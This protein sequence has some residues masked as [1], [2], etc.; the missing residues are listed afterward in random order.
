MKRLSRILTAALFFLV[1]GIG[2][3]AQTSTYQSNERTPGYRTFGLNGGLAYQQS[4]LPL[5]IDGGWGVG[6]TLAKNIYY[7]PGDALGFD[8]RGRALY[9]ESYG[10]DHKRSY[11]VNQNEMLNGT[12]NLDYTK[13]AGESGFVFHNNKTH[14]GELGLEGVLHF[15]RLRERTNWDLSLFGGIGLGWYKARM[16]Q[17]NNGSLYTTAYLGIDTTASASTI[18]NQLRNQ[19]LDDFYETDGQGMNDWGNLSIMPGAGIELGYQLTPKFSIGVGHKVTFTNT[20]IFDG[21]RHENNGSPSTE[22]DWHHYTNLN[23]RWIIDP[24]QKKTPGPKVELINPHT[25]VQTVYSPKGFVRARVKNVHSAMEVD[26][27]VNGTSTPFDFDNGI[28]KSH[29]DLQEGSNKIT[30]SAYN[31][32]GSDTESATIVYKNNTNDNNDVVIT[33]PIVDDKPMDPVIEEDEDDEDY[34]DD[35]PYVEM[36]RVN[37]TRPY[38]S[39]ETVDNDRYTVRATIENVHGRDD[40]RFTVNGRTY[41][42]FAFRNERFEAVVDLREG[43]NSIKIEGRNSRGTRSDNATIKLVVDRLQKPMV[44]ITRPYRDPYTT[45]NTSETIEATV[46]PVDDGC[47]VLFKV[48]GRSVRGW[49]LNGERFNGTANLRPGRN[50]VEVV[51]ANDAGQSSD[52]IIIYYEQPNQPDPLTVKITK[53]YNDPHT[54]ENSR[55]RIDATIRPSGN[56]CN[57]LFKVN[58]RSVQRF[59]LNGERFR[60]N[61]DLKLGRNEIEVIAINGDDRASDRVTIIYEKP[62]Q[63]VLPKV[64]ITTPNRNGTTTNENRT[65]IKANIDHV[66]R[67]SDIIFTING[68]TSNDFTFDADK[69]RF[70]GNAN[71]KTGNNTVKIEATNRDGRDDDQVT[72]KYVIEKNP[73]SVDIRQPKNKAKTAKATVSFEGRVTNIDRKSDIQLLLNG[74]RIDNFGF[75]NNK[76]TATLTLRTGKNNIVLKAQ[77]DDGS[78]RDEVQIMYNKPIINK[79]KPPTVDIV[80]PRK[81]VTTTKSNYNITAK[82]THVNSSRDITVKSNGKTIRFDFDQRRQ[83]ISA[84]VRLTNGNN[85]VVVTVKNS[86]GRDSDSETI[87]KKSN[88]SKGDDIVISKPK[89]QKPSIDQFSLSQPST[90]PL[91]PNTAKTRISGLL[92]NVSSKSEITLVFDGQRVTNFDFNPRTGVLNVIMTIGRGKHSAKVTVNTPGGKASKTARVTF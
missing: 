31:A 90:D 45:N 74:K 1:L 92:K 2:L 61:A 65:T 73:P 85:K 32:N 84:T 89:Y 17:T 82:V 86:T 18:R 8:L 81:K 55:E 23:L 66:A 6:L 39:T 4:D 70:T 21:V 11:S 22:N 16:N 19:I 43:R 83:T 56:G 20:D 51:A 69:G 29:F 54:T 59:D 76:V 77:N 47:N 35:Q 72:I 52:R 24:A 79:P 58:G 63:E 87:V 15:N 53:P 78:D 26:L 64:D 67:K 27:I 10:L 44:N 3:D 38:R 49:D 75:S 60:G 68:R 62:Y 48:N 57:V 40:V 33:D 34:F 80:T 9:T 5:T 13:N 50:E 42:D 71:L 14:L 30:V 91:N 25:S 37:I 36:P 12:V 46:R 28:L 41:Y 88:I 7:R